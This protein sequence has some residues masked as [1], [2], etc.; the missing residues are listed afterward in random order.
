M[1][2]FDFEGALD[3]ARELVATEGHVISIAND[4]AGSRHTALD[5]EHFVGDE[6][7]RANDAA[8]SADELLE[9]LLPK[10]DSTA[11]AWAAEWAYV[12]GEQNQEKY[13]RLAEIVQRENDSKIQAFYRR[14]RANPDGKHAWPRLGS[15]EPPRPVVPPLRA[16]NFVPE[17]PPF[18][19]YSRVG[20][21]YVANYSW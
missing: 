3:M 17:D 10:L 5:Q 13:E 21:D 8:D 7:D 9:M 2:R 1:I 11:A 15:I 19:S 4:R 18:V 12:I 20:L 16:Q 6:A 14:Y